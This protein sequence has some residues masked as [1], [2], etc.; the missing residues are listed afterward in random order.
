M[1]AGDSQQVPAGPIVAAERAIDQLLPLAGIVRQQPI[2]GAGPASAQLLVVFVFPHRIGMTEDGEQGKL[3]QL[4]LSFAPQ[5]QQVGEGRGLLNGSTKDESNSKEKA[6][7]SEAGDG[8]QV[9][10]DGVHFRPGDVGRVL[11]PGAGVAVE[12][13]R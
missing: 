9:D 12:G 7:Q 6:G 11:A 1:P 3:P 2:N 13:R 4:V 8:N 5:L 10:A